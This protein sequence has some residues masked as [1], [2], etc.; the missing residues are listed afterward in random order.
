[1]LENFARIGAALKSSERNM[2]EQ[3]ENYMKSITSR[4]KYSGQIYNKIT[5]DCNK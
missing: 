2:E 4:V 5:G 3:I 1:M